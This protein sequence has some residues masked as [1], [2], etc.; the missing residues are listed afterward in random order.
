[1]I[2]QFFAQ[3]HPRPQI[4]LRVQ[5]VGTSSSDTLPNGSYTVILGAY[6]TVVTVSAS[7]SFTLPGSLFKAGQKVSGSIET[8]SGVKVATISTTMLLPASSITTMTYKLTAFNPSI[9][10]SNVTLASSTDRAKLTLS[11]DVD[12]W[13]MVEN[14]SFAVALQNADGRLFIS[15]IMYTDRYIYVKAGIMSSQAIIETI[16]LRLYSVTGQVVEKSFTVTIFS[17]GSGELPLDLP[18]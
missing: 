6:Q 3:N 10:P 18:I 8:Q 9:T 17:E 5:L 12:H 11:I 15:G 7:T 13:E 1:M 4:D 2:K 16:N 14:F